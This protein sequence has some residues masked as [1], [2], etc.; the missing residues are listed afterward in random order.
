M[1]EL[2]RRNYTSTSR[3]LP[4]AA[5]TDPAHRQEASTSTTPQDITDKERDVL[6]AA[7]RVDQAGEVAANWIYRG[8]LAVLGRDRATGP[9]IQVSLR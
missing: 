7:L 8:Q 6:H 2:A 9:L 5:Y 4:S 3:T 1:S